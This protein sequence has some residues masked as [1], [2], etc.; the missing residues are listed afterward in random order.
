MKDEFPRCKLLAATISAMLGMLA[1]TPLLAQSHSTEASHDHDR[2]GADHDHHALEEVLV[3]ATPL[4]RD[5]VEISQSAT[6]LRGDALDREL[7]NNVGDTL[8]RLPGLSNASFG[9][10]VGRPAIR[11]LQGVRIG[12]LND[13]MTSLDASALSQ[14]HAVPT[15][16]FLA[17]QV[18]V[19]RGPATLIY[20]SGS[21]GGVVNMVT[22]TIPREVPDG[23][24]SARALI[25]GDSA[26][27]QRFAAGRIDLGSGQFAFH[28][29]AF[30]RRSDDYE[31]PGAAELYPNVDEDDH[32][33]HDEE[34]S[35]VLENSFLDNQ[36]GAVGASWIG[37]RWTAGV[38]Y[39]AYN[40]DYGIP[41]A[42]AH[43]HQEEA[44]DEEH[45]EHDEHEDEDLVNVGLKNRRIDG[46]LLGQNPFSGFN[47]F[48]LNLTRTEY[49][50]TEFEGEE[51]GTVFDSESTDGRLELRHDPWG[52]WEGVF[53]GQY[54]DRQF[55][56]AGA[57]AFVPPSDTHTW[58]LF[59]V[60]SL[61]RDRWRFDL[62]LR[63]EDVNQ[64]ALQLEHGH[65]E[66]H[67]D[68][69]HEDPMVLKRNFNP[70]SFS[71]AAIWHVNEA[72]HLAFTF[73]G[74]ERAPSD[75]ELFANGPHIATQTFEVGDPDLQE[76]QNMHYELAWRIH[77][78][79]LTGSISL[80]YD[81]F[82]D[83]IYLEDSGLEE[84]GLPLREWSQ[85]NAEFFGGEIELRWD[86]GHTSSGHWQLFGLYDRVSAE[87]S[88][89]GNVPLLPPQ[90]FGAGA[91]WDLYGW[92][93]N[94]TWINA[95]A[96]TDTAEYET[97]TPGY[98]LVNAEL[99]Y[100]F[101]LKGG[102]ALNLFLKGRNL[103]NEDI[104]NSTSYLKDQA[105][106]IGRNFILGA[107]IVY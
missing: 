21:I 94:L 107:S 66:D 24:M 59:W 57:E 81:N 87:L 9:Q 2:H 90:R 101:K 43:E 32:D 33:E 5:V 31:I 60:E 84:D 106:Q 63:Y 17:D 41:G 29:N 77:Q 76:E 93:A 69:D 25:Q 35:G 47:Q 36:G 88:D 53:G 15:E 103:L 48:K 65:D 104:R 22:N 95:S 64:K 92:A 72:N 74:A 8:A 39:T 12:V 50:H 78:G 30:Y 10:N 46:L 19:L 89:G 49:T 105:P 37:D 97:A 67:H 51:V 73:A 1:S 100:Q 7:S 83:Y 96:H 45:D 34:A 6:V 61:E 56:A 54:T 11:G 4:Q 86:L 23:G 71:A 38:A 52:A 18:E 91:D 82:R 40:S 98:D 14:D 13:N 68:E 27:D 16:P 79:A 75:A 102:S 99:S 42:H 20:G 62:G 70:L 80:Y 85:Q 58:G 44:H 28:A 26:A 3:T 55:S